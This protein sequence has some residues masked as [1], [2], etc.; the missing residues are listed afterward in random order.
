MRKLVLSIAFLG[1]F[2]TAIFAQPKNA[3]KVNLFSPIL[4]TGSFF[5]ER[6]IS[7]TSSLNLGF[8]FTAMKAGDTKFSGFAITPEYRFYLGEN[9]A[10]DGFYVAPYARYS[11]FTLKNEDSNYDFGSGN[12][13]SIEESKATLTS[14]GGGLVIGRQWIF[15]ERISLDMFIGPSYSSAS[16]KADID[17]EEGSFDASIWD[18][19]GV[20]AGLTLGIAF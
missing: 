1:V 8:L 16:I 4:K 13:T 18:G 5:Y 14:I 6:A 11:S 19:F 15:K 9:G 17:S 20:R 10:M 3:I 7:E 12:T 2:C